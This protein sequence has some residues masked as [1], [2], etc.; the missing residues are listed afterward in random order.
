MELLYISHQFSMAHFEHGALDKQTKHLVDPQLAAKR[1]LYECP[2]CKRDV[3]VRKGEIKVPHFAHRKDKNSS[4]TYFTRNPSKD[5]Q[6]RNAQLKLKQFL[7]RGI[8]VEITRRCIASCGR[9]SNWGINY[10]PDSIIKL[11]HRFK[12]ND[13]TKVAD[14]VFLHGGKIVV[15][16]EVVHTH[17]TKERDRPEPWHEVSAS[18][19]N[20][21]PSD[22]TTVK[23]TCLRQEVCRGC[24][25]R[26]NQ[27]ERLRIERQTEE[28]NRR[29]EREREER[30]RFEEW[31]KKEDERIEE[32]IRWDKEWRVRQEQDYIRSHQEDI[33]YQKKQELAKQEQFEED[34]RKQSKEIPEIIRQRERV[35][36]YTREYSRISNE[37]PIC[38]GCKG[39]RCTKC[40]H[41]I[42]PIWLKF[43]NEELPKIFA[44]YR[45]NDD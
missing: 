3:F 33:D 21:I 29:A 20:K 19:I 15:I 43:K 18:E 12:Y 10:T 1:I 42:G 5:Q 45:L 25:L 14:V 11:E 8:E 13:S 34:A 22:S 36:I 35:K 32:R 4:C 37:V 24:I 41:I 7:E 39:P 26:Q 28:N 17:Y 44:E 40:N 27:E 16:F 9:A 31:V 30:S 38:S 6:H 2:D 23:L